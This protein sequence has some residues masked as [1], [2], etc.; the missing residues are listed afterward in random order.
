MELSKEQ[1][2]QVENYL[3]SKNITYIDLRT[4]VLDHIVSEIE[5]KIIENEVTFHHA[6]AIAKQNWNPKLEEAT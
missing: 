2:Q 3:N 6:F 1:I 5:D 4:E